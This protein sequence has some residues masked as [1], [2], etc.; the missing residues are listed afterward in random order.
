MQISAIGGNLVATPCLPVA[1]GAVS[2]VPAALPDFPVLSHPEYELKIVPQRC[3]LRVKEKWPLIYKVRDYVLRE[4]TY[5][6]DVETHPPETGVS[7]TLLEPSENVRSFMD[8]L[9]GYFRTKCLE[10]N[11]E[12]SYTR[13][14]YPFSE[15]SEH[16]YSLGDVEIVR[17]PLSDDP[18]PL[19]PPIVA[20]EDRSLNL[21]WLVNQDA[22]SANAAKS[23]FISNGDVTLVGMGD[24]QGFAFI[25]HEEDFEWVDVLDFTNLNHAAFPF[26]LIEEMLRLS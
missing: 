7:L 24:P 14:A 2:D 6:V 25:H 8:A 21:A 4:K 9:L 20:I 13:D 17:Y 19:L 1:H 16:L 26:H 15:V 23:I 18:I 22:L 3:M 5:E 11:W 10:V 12:V